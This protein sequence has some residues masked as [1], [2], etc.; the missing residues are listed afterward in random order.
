MDSDEDGNKNK[1]EMKLSHRPVADKPVTGVY[2][3]PLDFAHHHH[4]HLGRITIEDPLAH[5]Y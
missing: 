2:Y 3:W 4:H 1:K 5:F